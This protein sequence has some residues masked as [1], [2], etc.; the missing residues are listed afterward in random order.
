MSNAGAEDNDD[1]LSDVEAD[2]PVPIDIINSPSPEDVSIEKFREILAELDRERQ[3]RLAA[4]DSKSQLQ[5]SFNR[6][7]VLAHDAIKSGMST[8]D[9]AMKHCGKR[10]KLR[11]QLER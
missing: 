6:L 11:Q 2:D 7:R 10:K 4:E 1:V 8:R 5:V 9:N 3:A